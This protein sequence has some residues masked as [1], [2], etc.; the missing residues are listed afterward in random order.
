MIATG[1]AY[2]FGLGPLATA[3]LDRGA[4][5][6]PVVTQVLSSPAVRDWFYHRARTPT[7]ADASAAWRGPARRSS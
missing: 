1:A 7:G 2:R 4:G 6:W 5:R 3:L